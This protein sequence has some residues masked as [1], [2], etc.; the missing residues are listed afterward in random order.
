[1]S[2]V[3][4]APPPAQA[5]ASPAPAANEAVINPNPVASQTPVGSQ[6]PEAPAANKPPPSRRD[7]IKAAFAKA[8]AP[9]A[10]PGKQP[11]A[12]AK[13]AKVQ[14]PVQKEPGEGEFTLKR[15]PQHREAGRF[16]RAPQG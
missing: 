12:K 10:E 9:V 7:A 11:A 3:N 4:I 2:D 6:A 15:P 8:N 13:A 16:A 14:A 1:M 5:P